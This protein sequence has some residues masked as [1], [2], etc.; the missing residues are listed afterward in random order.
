MIDPACVLSRKVHVVH[1]Q[2]VVNTDT[3]LFLCPQYQMEESL[4]EF[5]STSFIV[6]GAY[7]EKQL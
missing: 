6:F 2:F 4:V 3:L 1:E 5:I 7:L